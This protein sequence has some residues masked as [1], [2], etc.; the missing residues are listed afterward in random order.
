VPGVKEEIQ[1]T[2]AKIIITL[3]IMTKFGET[4]DFKGYDFVR[5]IEACLNRQLDAIIYNTR[6][7][8]NRLLKKYMDEKAEFVELE[9]FE[10]WIGDRVIYDGD[11]LDTSTEIARHDPIKLAALI[12]KIIFKKDDIDFEYELPENHKSDLAMRL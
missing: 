6:R 11:L 8:G 12:K 5:K 3:N 9:K 10:N 4:H 2:S 7:P 1:R